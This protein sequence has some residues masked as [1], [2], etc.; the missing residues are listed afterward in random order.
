[1]TL[2]REAL[3]HLFARGLS[4]V[5]SSSVFSLIA[6]M[7]GA[8]DAKVV[9]F[10]MFG[11]GFVAAFLRSFC[12]FS[13]GLRGGERRTARLRQIHVLVRRYV[14][15]SP[16][17]ALATVAVL[18]TQ[19][20]PTWLLVAS[21]AVL[22]S[23][24]LDSDLLRAALGQGPR[25]SLVF[26]LGNLAA[27]LWLL[28]FGGGRSIGGLAVLFPWGA[29]ALFNLAL[30]VRLRGRP[31]A[32]HSRRT[33][34]PAQHLPA[35][36]L[37]A[38]Y[39]GAVLNLPFIAGSSLSPAAGVDLSV[40]LR[41]FSSAQP[42]FPLVNHW[43]SSGRIQRL[44]RRLHTSDTV[45]Y[46]AMLVLSGWAASIVFITLYWAV[47]KG[48]VTLA[49]YLIFSALLA[50]I[51]LFIGAA[52]FATLALPPHW[53]VRQLAVGLALYL[54]TWFLLTSISQIGAVLAGA[55]QACA[56]SSVALSTFCLARRQHRSR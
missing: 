32:R 12:L 27:V 50:S 28:T 35:A 40:A 23:A 2:L 17:F 47:G 5:L 52:R 48:T 49:Q 10:F 56:L 53:R 16:L 18:S 21:A 42:F 11:T 24:G 25:F 37:T 30:L 51:A 14:R 41:L 33:A 54:G 36:L 6:R 3:M 31:S 26:A 4:A 34:L 39:D 8:P 9:F 45:L 29:V 19:D 46:A 1:M 55:L 43:A 44:A 15:L 38:L 22:V 20:V 13:A 7:N